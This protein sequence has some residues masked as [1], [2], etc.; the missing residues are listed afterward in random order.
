M[1][2]DDDTGDT[3][4]ITLDSILEPIKR[5]G[6]D[7]RT[8]ALKLGDAEARF[9]V[10]AY[11]IQQDDRKRSSAQERTLEEGGE[12]N[13]VISWL[14][15]QSETLEKQILAALDTYTKNHLMGSWMREIYGIGPVISAG[16]LANIY[17]GMWCKTCHGRDPKHCAAK[18]R[19]K[20]LKVAKHTY[21][22]ERS[23]PTAGHIWQFAGIAG[24][25]QKPWTKGEKRPFNARLK[26]LQWKTGQSFMKFSNDPQCIYGH[27]YKA[28]KQKYIVRNDAGEYRL[29]A[30]EYAPKVNRSTDVWPWYNACYPAGTSSAYERTGTGLPSVK[31]QDARLAYLKSARLN[32]GRG[33]HLLPPGHIDGMARRWAVKI[34]ISHLHAAWYEK[35]F[36][37]PAPAPYP[38]A[39]L[40]HTHKI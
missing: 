15:A 26:T 20:K 13:L 8:A 38:I 18:Q 3:D 10:D 21:A 7:L 4:D 5:L 30:L 9:L 37:E 22:E 36:N 29:R 24:D 16:L 32:P 33:A 28:Q 27:H 40:G 34:F 2:I 11:Y 35:Q 6:R 25:G 17:M 12:P 39:I 1:A 31:K 14:A 19:D 23:C